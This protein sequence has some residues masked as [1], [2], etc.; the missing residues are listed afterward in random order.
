MNQIVM[1][2]KSK[3]IDICVIEDSIICE[4]YVHDI[5]NEGLLGNIYAGVVSNVVEGMQAAFVDIGEER[6]A[7]MPVKDALPKIDV[8]KNNEFEIKPISEVVTPQ[9]KILVQVV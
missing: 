1:N 2:K 4:K 9:Q 7:F 6:N 5:E 3:K 8:V